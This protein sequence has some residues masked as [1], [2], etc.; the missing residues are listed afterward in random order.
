M[1]NCECPRPQW[2]GMVMPQTDDEIREI[3]ARYTQLQIE[4]FPLLKDLRDRLPAAV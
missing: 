4:E 1:P 2:G 3:L